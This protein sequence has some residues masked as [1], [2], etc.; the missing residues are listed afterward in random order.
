MASTSRGEILARVPLFA[1]LTSTEREALAARAVRKS[2]AAGERL[3]SEGDPCPGM[4][5][6]VAGRVKIFKTSPAGREI[7]LAVE[8]APSTVAEVPLFDGGPFPASVV[9]LEQVL[10]WLIRKEDFR[11]TC[12]QNPDLAL[13]LLAVTGRRLRQLVGLLEAVTFGS[14]RQRLARTLLEFADE[15]GTEKFT[16][17]V[18]Q[19]ELASRLGTVREVI[20]RNLSRFQAQGLLRIERRQLLLLDRP[21]LER[22]CEL[23]I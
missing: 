11:Q 4:Y 18:T 8:R 13:K 19:E 2:Y 17:P 12:R 1:G 21:G 16:L 7:M 3:F 9:A 6:L 23:E 15:A 20:S 14:V 10:A 5:V 22:E